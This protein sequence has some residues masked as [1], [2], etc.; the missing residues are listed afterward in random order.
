MNRLQDLMQKAR[1]YLPADSPLERIEQAYQFSAQL[2]QAQSKIPAAPALAHGLEISHIMCDLQLDLSCMV[3]GLLHGALEGFPPNPALRETMG[4]EVTALV[5]ELAKLSRAAFHSSEDSRASHM[6]EMI[7]STTRDIRVI[8][9][10]LAAR[11]HLMRVLAQ[12][13]PSERHAIARE[14]LLI[15]APIAH[16]LGIHSIKA[17][18]ED[19]AF[20]EL[21]PQAHHTLKAQLEQ[22]LSQY[23]QGIDHINAQL[24]RLLAENGMQGEVLGRTKHLYSIHQKLTRNQCELDQ[25]YDLLACRI[26]LESKEDCYRALGLI[27]AAFTPMPGRFKDYIALPKPNGYQSLHSTVVA[28]EGLILEI[29]LRTR[30]MHQ[31]ADLGIAAHFSYKDGRP[32]DSREIQNL[33]WFRSLLENLAPGKSPKE[34]LELV[35]RDLSPE[36]MFLFTPTGEVIKLPAMATPIDF[37]YAVHTQV[38][39]HC[40]GARQNG[41]MIPIRAPLTDGA[42]VEILTSPRQQPHKDWLKFARTSKALSRIRVYLS[43]QEKQEAVRLGRDMLAREAKHKGLKVEEIMENAAFKDWMQHHNYPQPEE[44]FAAVGFGRVVP[45]E[46]LDKLFPGTGRPLRVV[47]KGGQRLKPPKAASGLKPQVRVAGMSNMVLRFA[48]CCRPVYGDPIRGIITRGRGMSIHHAD[49]PNLAR[50]NHN[51]DRLLDADWVGGALSEVPL[52][53]EIRVE[54]GTKGLVQVAALLDELGA[55][56]HNTTLSQMDGIQLQRITVMVA[57]SSMVERILQRLNALEGIRAR[58]TLAS[59]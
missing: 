1:A 13:P 30:A 45:A 28:Q 9:I 25:L 38:G 55:P 17:E 48:Q 51:P 33:A 10:L 14:T 15:Y 46:V 35:D 21:E 52:H 47:E 36:E 44:F 40:M 39:N 26:I 29:Q 59:A 19:L 5:E 20:L 22:K 58:R 27:H 32:V 23:R 11:L 54:Q 43:Q 3:A 56:I 7:L 50:E 16:R 8:L 53:L 31:Q 42:V 41:R 37:A 24:Q 12:R 57:E 18:L 2:L 4:P 6:R 34:M 49:C